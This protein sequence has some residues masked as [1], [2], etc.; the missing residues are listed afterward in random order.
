MGGTPMESAL[1]NG[2]VLQWNRPLTGGGPCMEKIKNSVV[3]YPSK[4]D[5]PRYRQS[6]SQHTHLRRLLVPRITPAHTT[7]IPLSPPQ[8]HYTHTH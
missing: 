7:N 3:A 1:N 2:G 5:N 8:L 6:M 4:N